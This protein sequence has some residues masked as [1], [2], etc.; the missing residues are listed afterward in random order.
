MTPRPGGEWSSALSHLALGA[1]SL[2]A[3][4]STAQANRGAAAGFLLQ[5]LAAAIMLASGLGT[6]EDCLAGAWV[7]TVIGLP[8]LA[9]DFHWVNGDCSSANLLLGGGMVLAVAGDHLG[10]EGRSVAGQAVVLV[11]AVTIL[12]VAVFTTNSYG[13]WGGVMLGAAGLLSRLEEDRLLLLLPKEDICRWA[14]AGGS[15]AYHRALHT[16]RLQ[17]E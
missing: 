6:D 3:A 10:A 14:L 7:A 13:M 2:H 16:Q 17:W 5:A 11:V 1:V 12:I 4:L 9:F 8:L 15:W